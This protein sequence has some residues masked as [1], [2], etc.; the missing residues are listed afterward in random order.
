MNSVADVHPKWKRYVLLVDEI[1]GYFE[2]NQENFQLVRVADLHLPDADKFL[3]R[4]DLLEANTAVKPWLLEWLFRHD[5]IEK[6]VYL[7]PDICVYRPL[8][9]A[10]QLLSEGALMTLTPHLLD[11]LN[12]GNRP[13]DRDILRAGCYNLGFIALARH[14]ELA[15][16]LGWWQSKL[17]FDCRVDLP[18]GVFVDQKWMDLAPGLFSDVAILRHPGYNV[19]YWNLS[20]RPVHFQNDEPRVADHPLVFFHFSGLD[21]LSPGDLSKHQDRY[22]L[23]DLGVCGKLVRS[24]C[25]AVLENGWEECKGW[26]YSFSVLKDGTP[27]PARMRRFYRSHPDIIRR[28]G[29]NPF[30]HSHDYLNDSWDGAR[31]PL[32]TRL[33]HEIWTSRQD[34]RDAFPDLQGAWREHYA[35][36]FIEFATWQEGIPESFVAPVRESLRA[37]RAVRGTAS[38]PAQSVFAFPPPPGDDENHPTGWM[39]RLLSR[40]ALTVLPVP[41]SPERLHRYYRLIRPMRFFLPTAIRRQLKRDVLHWYHRKRSAP[42]SLGLKGIILTVGRWLRSLLPRETRSEIPTTSESTTVALYAEP[43]E[44]H[45]FQTT[46]IHYKMADGI[47][48]VGYLSANTGVGESVRLC[49]Q[50]ALASGLRFS[51]HNVATE[52]DTERLDSRWIPHFGED[53]RHAVNVFHVNADQIQVV[54]DTLGASFFANRYNIG[55]WHW[56]LPTFPDRLFSAFDLVD[57]IWAPSRFIQDAIAARSPRPVVKIP[58]AIRFEGRRQATRA[59]FALPSDDLLFL[60]MYDVRSFQQRK[61]PEGAIEAFQ[62]AFAGARDVTLVVKVNN[63]RH[64]PQGLERLKEVLRGVSNVR[65]LDV[66]M[67]RQMTYDL[68]SVC[69]CMVSLHRA[70]G[71]GLVLAEAMF[72]GKPVIATGWSGNMEF[73][74]PDNSCPVEFRLV[75]LDRDIGPYERGQIWAEPDLDHAADLMK[76]IAVETSWR[77]KIGEAGRATI[78]NEFSPERIGEL[79]RQRLAAILNRKSSTIHSHQTAA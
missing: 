41:R 19:A 53:N 32:I 24:Y 6:V 35:S 54:R 4:Y 50:A 11:T 60:M 33:M 75:A 72:L 52:M 8:A 30:F 46:Q 29:S 17:E 40:I 48:L 9:D 1:D 78:V 62:K 68:Q 45:S 34:L 7:D 12:D 25:R 3:F 23:K 58:H 49:A 64:H 20:H 21:P 38:A 71:F 57:E 22:R 28:V 5:S 2:P 55:V 63:S 66:T 43:H 10:E 79:Y 31:Q 16:F 47:N 69:D 44:A 70:E 51:L 14:R 73:M 65:I 61:N 15:R 18:E 27:I 59:E 76:K 42:W 74:R 13:N 37:W 56:E 26:P 36:H 77:Q 39:I 67:D